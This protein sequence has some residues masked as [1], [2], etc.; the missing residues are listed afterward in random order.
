M[1]SDFD[2]YIAAAE[3]VKEKSD[4]NTYMVASNGDF[5]NL[6]FANR[7]QPWVVDDKL[8][9]DPMVEKMVRETVKIFRDNG[10]EARAT[11]WRKD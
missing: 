8:T 4:G 10:Y 9:V 5:Q 2:K 11:Q 6:F 1:L 7:E 3:I